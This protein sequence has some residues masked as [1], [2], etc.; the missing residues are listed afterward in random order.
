MK[1]AAEF[2]LDWLID[3]GQGQL[4]TAPSTSPE[5]KFV[6]PDGRHAAVSYAATMDLA[7][8]LGP[9]QQ[10]QQASEVLGSRRRSRARLE[11]ARARLLPYQVEAAASC[12]SGPR[13]S[14]RR[15]REHRHFSHLFGL[16]PGREIT[17]RDAG[18][19]RR[20][21]ALDGAARRRR[22]RL[23]DGVEDQ[24]LGAHARRRSRVPLAHEPAQ[25]GAGRSASATRAAASTRTC[26]TR[27]RR[28]RSTAT[29]A[30]RGHR[31]DAAPEPRR[32][33][34]PAAGAAVGVAA[35]RAWPARARRLR[36]R[37]RVAAR[38]VDGGGD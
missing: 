22:H 28:S 24:L 31:R 36:D 10:L 14:S 33:D 17:P 9:V 27:I 37:Y 38:G 23:V 12:R 32:R 25:A 30:R 35:G 19:L 7:R 26:S 6:L 16:Y 1:G 15:S 13:T 3:D 21:A 20:G 2:C 18:A 11:Q 5:H 29:S 4:V 34:P 8:D